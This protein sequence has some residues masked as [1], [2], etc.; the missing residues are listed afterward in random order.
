MTTT[1]EEAMSNEI[2]K[3][4]KNYINRA[5]TIF[6]ETMSVINTDSNKAKVIVEIAKMIQLEEKSQ[7]ELMKMNYRSREHI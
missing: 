5:K 7:M 3:K 2:D 4:V 6:S 1:V